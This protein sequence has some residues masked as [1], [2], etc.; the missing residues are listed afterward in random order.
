MSRSFPHRI[1]TYKLM[2]EIL[3]ISFQA[4]TGHTVVYRLSFNQSGPEEKWRGIIWHITS[5]S[6]LTF[7]I[8]MANILPRMHFPS[9]ISSNCLGLRSYII[10]LK[11]FDHFIFYRI[12]YLSHAESSHA[13][14]NPFTIELLE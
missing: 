13:H 14:Q 11:P 8:A 7:H 10:I 9:Q 12:V 2:T 6:V 3:P 4:S 5:I 1:G